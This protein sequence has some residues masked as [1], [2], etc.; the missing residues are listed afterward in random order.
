M[1]IHKTK[2]FTI[3]PLVL[4]ATVLIAVLIS[5]PSL[6]W[7][8]VMRILV[9]GKT[10]YSICPSMMGGSSPEYCVPTKIS[11]PECFISWTKAWDQRK[12]MAGID[13][14]FPKLGPQCKKAERS[15]ENMVWSS[16]K[17]K[18]MAESIRKN[19]SFLK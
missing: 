6:S 4:G 3:V 15:Y 2:I 17:G 7:A 5:L 10:T 19:T 14:H 1:K 8:G 16:P 12:K 13:Y 18:R 11:P 9:D